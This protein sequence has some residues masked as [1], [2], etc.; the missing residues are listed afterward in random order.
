MTLPT[1]PDPN[2]IE[3]AVVTTYRLQQE[4]ETAKK[5]LIKA[6][7]E[8]VDVSN[9]FTTYLYRRGS[10]IVFDNLN[11]LRAWRDLLTRIIK[12]IEDKS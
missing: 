11:E 6:E 2:K 4:W 1:L 7:I 3:K 9:I 10:K 12:L 8:H 5:R